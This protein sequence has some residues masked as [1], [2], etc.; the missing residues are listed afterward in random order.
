MKYQDS[1][2]HLHTFNNN[3]GSVG[4]GTFCFIHILLNAV[5]NSC[6]E[7]KKKIILLV[8]LLIFQK[9]QLPLELNSEIM[10]SGL[11]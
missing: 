9:Q 11:F 1:A 10:T 7:C 4:P 5:S 2:W 6:W 8:F 3:Y